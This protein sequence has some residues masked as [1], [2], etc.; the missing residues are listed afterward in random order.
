MSTITGG[1]GND[2]LIGTGNDTLTGGAGADTFII[3]SGLNTITDLGNGADILS[4]SNGATASATVYGDFTATN[5]TINN[6]AALIEANGHTVDLASAG[7]GWYGWTIRNS[8]ATGATLAG[9]A[10]NDIISGGTGNDTLSGGGG[11]DTLTGGA[12]ADTFDIFSGLNTI[13]D[14]GN[15]A[16][17]LSVDSGA[18][19]SATAYGNLTATSEIINNGTA[20]I[21]ANG[22]TVNLASAGGLNGWTITN[23]SAKGVTLAGSA[24]N[25][26]I[27]GG[28]G[29]N[30]LTGGAGADTFNILSGYNT[31]TDFG[32]GADILKVSSGATASATAYGN[33]TATSAIINNGTAWIDAHGHTVNLA[34]AGGRNGWTLTNSSATGVT[35]AGSAHND[36]ISGG[37]GN[38]TLSGG[39][40]A[41]TFNILS[42][43]NTITDLGNGADILSVSRGAAA[44]A[45]VYGNFTA[46]SATINYGTASI[47]ANGHNVDLTSAGSGDYGWTIRNSSATGAT[48]AG[49]ALNDIISGGTGNDTL[50]GSGGNNT[51]VFN[52]APNTSTN[53]DT[54]T[55]FVHGTDIFQFSHAIFYSINSWVSNEFYSAPGAVTGH[56]STDRIVYN[57]TTGNLYYDVDGSGPRLAVLVALIGTATHPTLDWQ[58][59]QLVA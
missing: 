4:V 40:G 2:M 34:S 52:T 23:S 21:N 37:T 59:I 26:I 55:D 36:I 20:S 27:S 44:S 33:F 24:N 1:P 50:T 42:G 38:N 32:N 58:D 14:L 5:E 39:A 43:F 45:T 49:S 15:G 3:L 8:S 7:S 47:D 16:D 35:L 19:V 28:R 6:G 17:I 46:T 9:S 12:G 57:T 29:N 11:N 54:I 51:F 30:S 31:I 18:T 13:T 41:D 22:H 56:I 48:L 10:L 53:H 25:D